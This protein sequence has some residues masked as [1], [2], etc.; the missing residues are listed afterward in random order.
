[1]AVPF[2]SKE[3]EYRKFSF[4]ASPNP[5]WCLYEDAFPVT[6]RRPKPMFLETMKKENF[7]TETIWVNA[8]PLALIFWWNFDTTVYIEHLAVMQKQ[9]NNGLGGRILEDFFRRFPFG[10]TFIIE[11]EP[12]ENELARRRIEF[13][14]RHGMFLN[15]YP[16]EQ[17]GYKD[18]FKPLPLK[19]MTYPC[20]ISE[21]AS[22]HFKNKLVPEIYFMAFGPREIFAKISD[23]KPLCVDMD[24]TLLNGD[25]MAIGFYKLLKKN[26]LMA[27]PIASWLI[28]GGRYVFK[29]EITKRAKL[30]V[31]SLP[32]RKSMLDFVISEREKGRELVLATA[33]MQETADKVAEYLGI[34]DRA[35]GSKN[36]ENLRAANKRKFLVDLFGFRGFDY[37]GNS[38]ADLEVWEA[39]DKI[40]F[41]GKNRTALRK[42]Q[43][44]GRL[45]KKFE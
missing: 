26:P 30:D 28:K 5:F 41:A 8:E 14:K 18:I 35:V 44:T 33:S 4:S 42:I 32:Y 7:V 31:K 39:A 38:N 17:P 15:E 24:G 22:N 13:Y 6:E 20:A 11:V 27:F 12:P 3:F 37:A 45:F 36:G 10:T 2:D 43:E 9:R 29:N 23:L 21:E 40:I 19:L 34:F 16:Y 25:S 1:M